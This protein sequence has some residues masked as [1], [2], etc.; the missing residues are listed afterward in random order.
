MSAKLKTWQC[1][2]YLDALEDVHGALFL[3][4]KALQLLI[5]R[6]YFLQ[7]FSNLLNTENC[8]NSDMT[9]LRP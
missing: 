3:R 4:A 8:V 6:I 7:V 9:G 1:G 5:Y 2:R